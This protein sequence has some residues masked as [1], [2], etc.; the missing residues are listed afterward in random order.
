[1]ATL[2]IHQGLV[3]I[4]VLPLL[5]HLARGL[6]LW[7]PEHSTAPFHYASMRTTGSQIQL[8]TPSVC[9]CRGYLA[10]ESSFLVASKN[11]HGPENPDPDVGNPV[12]DVLWCAT[13]NNQ[14]R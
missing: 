7:L 10:V 11:S 5:C 6:V 9:P 3:I 14:S 8:D 2:R 1:M 13:R 4:E 12:Q